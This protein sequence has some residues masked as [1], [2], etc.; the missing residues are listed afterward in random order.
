MRAILILSFFTVLG[1]GEL[2]AF[3]MNNNTD[4]GMNLKVSSNEHTSDK[5]YYIAAH[6]KNLS[7]SIP[8]ATGECLPFDVKLNYNPLEFRW[9]R[10]NTT[11]DGTITI[12]SY[13]WD[14]LPNLTCSPTCTYQ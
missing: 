3:T 6:K 12:D 11:K 13:T 14:Q 7:G 10:C 9:R 2:I 5:G 4:Q 1:Q 8:A